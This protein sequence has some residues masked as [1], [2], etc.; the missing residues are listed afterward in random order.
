[1]LVNCCVLQKDWWKGVSVGIGASCTSVG[2]VDWESS[3][4]VP[5]KSQGVA[6]KTQLMLLSSHPC[7]W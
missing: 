7:M 3:A 1:M 2:T 4:E 6:L 5:F